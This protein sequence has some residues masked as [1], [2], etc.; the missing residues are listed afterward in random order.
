MSFDIIHYQN[1]LPFA[2]LTMFCTYHKIYAIT[3]ISGILHH[4]PML[5]TYHQIY[6]ITK[7]SG[8]LQHLIML[9]IYRQIYH[10]KKHR[11]IGPKPNL[12]TERNPLLSKVRKTGRQKENKAM[13]YFFIFV[14]AN[15]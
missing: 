2:S 5:C 3:K 10:Y 13:F 12:K 15:K 1:I 11:E 9:C 4:L 14:L 6:A 8:L 7:I